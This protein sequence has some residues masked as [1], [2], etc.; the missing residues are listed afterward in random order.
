M[1]RTE[2]RR[3][4]SKCITNLAPQECCAERAA[5]RTYFCP[6]LWG[7]AGG[8]AD[9]RQTWLG[10]AGIARVSVVRGAG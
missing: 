1:E 6:G 10:G 4:C 7:S 9:L 8:F 3:A 2:I 5:A